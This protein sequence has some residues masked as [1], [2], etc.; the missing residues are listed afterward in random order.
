M[1]Q[2]LREKLA[3]G[4]I[5]VALRTSIDISRDA[6]E[7]ALGKA[8]YDL[9]Y[10]DLQHSPYTERQ[11]QD[12]CA[13]AEDLGLPVEIRIPH[14]RYAHLAG[15]LCD[16][17]PAGILVPEVMTDHDVQESLDYFYYPPMGRRSFG[18]STRHGMKTRPNAR[19]YAD[20]WNQTGVLGLQLESVEAVIN[21]R[22]LAKPGVG[23][24]SFGPTDLSLS[25]DMHP[26]FPFRTVEECMRHVSVQLQGSGIPLGIAVTLKPE[27]RE[28]YLNVGLTVFQEAPRP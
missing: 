7:R 23:Y 21:A 27:E 17:G 22:L 18:G 1:T 15:R 2:S 6:L 13:A 28:R 24:V 8:E 25:M 26:D 4:Q 12:Y 14:T 3:S 9:L 20:W 10:T 11:L 19:V 5:V 16:F